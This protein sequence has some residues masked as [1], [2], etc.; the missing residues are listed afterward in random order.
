MPKLKFET[1]AN[2]STDNINARLTARYIGEYED[3]RTGLFTAPNPNWPT[4]GIVLPQ[5][6]TVKSFVSY[7]ATLV[8]SLPWETTV[9]FSVDNILDTDP[10]FARLELNYDP[11]TGD[12]IGRTFKVGITKRFGAGS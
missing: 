1:Y 2:A 9:S 6:Q 8:W 10:P 4:P 3:Q 11:F 12:P 7:D 5:G